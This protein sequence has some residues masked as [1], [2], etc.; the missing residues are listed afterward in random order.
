MNLKTWLTIY[1]HIAR[2]MGYNIVADQLAPIIALLLN[3]SRISPVSH[4]RKLI[5]DRIVFVVGAGPTLTSVLPRFRK[6]IYERYRDSICVVCADSA[7]TPLLDHGIIP[8]IVVSDLDGSIKHL[9]RAS[10]LGSLVILHG[11]GDNLHQ[12]LKFSKHLDRIIISTQVLPIYPI[13]NYYGYT[14]GDR[15]VC[16]AVKL[17]AK[18]IILIGM[19]LKAA[20][21]PYQKYKKL[22]KAIKRLKMK[23]AS[24]LIRLL[25][26]E[27]HILQLK[28][29]EGLK[30][31]DKIDWSNL[32]KYVL[33]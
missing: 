20:P 2:L 30:D 16:L 33:N 24:V 25:A 18:K 14:D 12:I 22:P 7:I 21:D 11:H 19:D 26:E 1:F 31:I 9:S 3:L 32:E 23:I 10:R 17:G 29:E 6:K 15:A 8:D 27:N 4:L 28:T 13:V 5:M